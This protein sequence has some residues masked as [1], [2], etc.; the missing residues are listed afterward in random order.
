M[1][2][3]DA[4]SPTSSIRIP[5]TLWLCA[6]DGS[7]PF[8]PDAFEESAAFW[9][10]VFELEAPSVARLSFQLGFTYCSTS[11]TAHCLNLRREGKKPTVPSADT[12]GTQLWAAVGSDR[13]APAVV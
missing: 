8:R 2:S 6:V 1:R 5:P 4:P 13:S 11:A 7:G 9:R 12:K 3:R 10:D